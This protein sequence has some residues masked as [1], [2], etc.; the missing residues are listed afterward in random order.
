MLPVCLK[1]MGN[2]GSYPTKTDIVIVTNKPDA[3]RNWRDHSAMVDGRTFRVHGAEDVGLNPL[4]LAWRHRDVATEA[5]ATGVPTKSQT[6][7]C[8]DALHP[9]CTLRVQ[10]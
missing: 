10:L 2:L 1:V 4:D 8:E 7:N 3:L 5:M 9:P 6:N